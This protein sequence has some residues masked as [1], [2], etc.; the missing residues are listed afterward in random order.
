[1]AVPTHEVVKAACAEPDS[2]TIPAPTN[3][4]TRVI[5]VAVIVLIRIPYP[6]L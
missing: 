1:L 6:Y 2:A 3:A 4:A 5:L